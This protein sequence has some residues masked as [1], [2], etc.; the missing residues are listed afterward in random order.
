MLVVRYL[1]G[2][3]W[4]RSV[5]RGVLLPV[6]ASAGASIVLKGALHRPF[7]P[8]P[9]PPPPDPTPGAPPPPPHDPTALVRKRGLAVL[10]DAVLEQLPLLC[11][12]A[13][14]G[15]KVDRSIDR[16]IVRKARWCQRD[17]GSFLLNTL[18]AREREA[19]RVEF[20]RIAE[21]TLFL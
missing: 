13:M 1:D 7:V 19:F 20:D 16:S 8:P 9:P 21:Y 17:A 10:R 3:S 2:A 15:I 6:W 18:R 5:A 12:A 11:A 14:I 4:P